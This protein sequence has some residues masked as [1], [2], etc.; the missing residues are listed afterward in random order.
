MSKYFIDCEFN[1]YRGELISMALVCEDGRSLYM[2]ASDTVLYFPQDSRLADDRKFIPYPHIDKWV[3]ENVLPSLFKSYRRPVIL[4]RA[5]M[6]I[7]IETFL[8]NDDA[9]IIIADWPDDIKYFCELVIT[10]PGT[11]IKV[12]GLTFEIHRVDAYPTT[13]PGAI[14]H[15]AF[16]DALALKHL[17]KK[18]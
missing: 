8:L 17:L 18:S 4:S 16:W 11:M 14:Q 7:A 2:I 1:G 13:L 3:L 9:P 10:G 6:A 12:P 15:N 5:K